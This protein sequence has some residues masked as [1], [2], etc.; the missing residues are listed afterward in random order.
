MKFNQIKDTISAGSKWLVIIFLIISVAIGLFL[1]VKPGVLMSEDV[2][3]NAAAIQ[4][5]TDPHV[6]S[7]HIFFVDWHGC[8]KK[9]IVAFD[10]MAKNYSQQ[11]VEI[12]ICCASLLRK[13][14]T[15]RIPTR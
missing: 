3:I 6:I 5:Y 4:N 13:G 1:W 11:K 9:D 12:V 8:D 2:A 14:C 7:K 10:V 15:L